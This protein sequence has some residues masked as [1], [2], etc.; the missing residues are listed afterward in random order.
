MKEN[1]SNLRELVGAAQSGD[2]IALL[3]IVQRFYPLIK[4]VK[5]KMIL[6]ERDDL[7]QEILEKIIRVIL[8]F[9]INSSADL[10]YFRNSIKDFV[11]ETAEIE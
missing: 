9:D 10:T 5:R 8:T 6:Q 4:K 3:E 7:E 1:K 11:R 2:Q